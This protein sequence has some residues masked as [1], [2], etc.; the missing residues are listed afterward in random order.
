MLNLL[1]ALFNLSTGMGNIFL[2]FHPP[3]VIPACLWQVSL[4]KSP[5]WIPDYNCREW[6]L[7]SVIPAGSQRGS[8]LPV[9]PGWL[10]QVSLLNSPRWIPDYNCREWLGWGEIPDCSCRAWR[11]RAIP[12]P[13]FHVEVLQ[14]VTARTSFTKWWRGPPYSARNLFAIYQMRCKR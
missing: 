6:P 11:V 5:R 12:V 3:F 4:W 7:P 2:I 1:G 13:R 8:I 9:I 14:C 10:W